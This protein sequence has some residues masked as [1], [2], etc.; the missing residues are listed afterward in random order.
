MSYA[1]EVKQLSLMNE[2]VYCVDC[3][4][5][6]TQW[7]SL[8]YGIFL[9]ME[10]A[11]IHR[12]MGV[13]ISVVKSINL[14]KWTE[15]G[16]LRMKI[17]GNKQFKDYLTNNEIINVS[18]VDKYKMDIVKEYK[19]NLQEKIEQA[20]PNIKKTPSPRVT[21]NRSTNNM[22]QNNRSTNNMAQYNQPTN[23]MAQYNQPTNSVQYNPSQTQFLSNYTSS[24]SSSDIKS[25]VSSALYK[26]TD[27]VSENAVYLKDKSIEYGSKLNET[28]LKPSTAYLKEKG[29]A[30]VS[31][32]NKK[33]DEYTTPGTIKN[34]K[35]DNP[36]K[37]D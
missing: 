15:E 13:R 31:K 20:M 22:A 33:Q 18:V 2:N 30:F 32:S 7:A 11:S 36:G 9:C 6:N 14:D 10:C 37:W 3:G 21:E 27:F 16:A 26:I 25:T 19:E 35:I 4:S 17:G 29:K 12:G 34:K 23:N 24:Y 8:S 28:V 5:K 1:D